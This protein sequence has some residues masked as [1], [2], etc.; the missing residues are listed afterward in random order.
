MG[1]AVEA[2]ERV[3]GDGQ[4]EALPHL[5]LHLGHAQLRVLRR[6]QVE[7]A[8]LNDGLPH[9]DA[10]VE[11]VEEQLQLEVGL[12]PV[13]RRAHGHDD[14]TRTQAGDRCR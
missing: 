3:V 11:V 10:P 8:L 4:L 14:F 5:E 7:H 1:G 13:A 9:R 12:R 6:L 2:V